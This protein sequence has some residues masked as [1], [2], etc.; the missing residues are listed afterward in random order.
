MTITPYGYNG[1]VY[2]VS[3][4]TRSHIVHIVDI[5]GDTCTCEHWI[6][7]LSKAEGDLAP[8]QRRC[9]HLK[10]VRDHYLDRIL[11]EINS[12]HHA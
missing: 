9:K 6:C 4:A 2:K 8:A 11:T 7:R 10:A 12:A 1:L 5:G 3:S